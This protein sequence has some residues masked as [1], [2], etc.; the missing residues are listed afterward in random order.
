MRKRLSG[1]VTMDP[2]DGCA[3]LGPAQPPASYCCL[4]V[5]A[6]AR[7]SSKPSSQLSSPGLMSHG[8]MPCDLG[9]RRCQCLP[10]GS[11]LLIP[12][13]GA[14]HLQ[15]LTPPPRTLSPAAGYKCHH[16]YSNCS[17]CSRVAL[18]GSLRCCRPHPVCAGRER[19]P[20]LP[21][22]QEEEGR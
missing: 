17:R 18:G 5:L 19:P 15:S 7:G 9:L 1:D 20:P 6:G 21:L 2:I 10:Q 12:F 11:P 16:D 8:L 22:P 4:S 3:P 14:L 13:H